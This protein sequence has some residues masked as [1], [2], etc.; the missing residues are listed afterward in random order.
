MGGGGSQTLR[1]DRSIVCCVCF[2]R[3]ENGDIEGDA[4]RIGESGGDVERSPILPWMSGSAEFDESESVGG[5][6]LL[7]RSVFLPP[8]EKLSLRATSRWWKRR[9]MSVE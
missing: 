6:E 9:R 4:M 1:G 3:R 5:G 2:R 8:R 7:S